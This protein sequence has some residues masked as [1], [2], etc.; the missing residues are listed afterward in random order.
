M[1]RI[2]FRLIV[3]AGVILALI[4]FPMYVYV[5]SA[6]TGGVEDIG[7]G[8]KFVDLYALSNFPFDQTN[9]T[10]EDVPKKW[11]ELDGQNVVLKGEMWQAFD[12]GNGKVGGFDLVYS[13][14]KCCVGTQPQIQHFVKA[15]VASGREAYYYPNQVMVTGKLHVDV[16]KDPEAGKVGQVYRLDVE[17]V[18][19]ST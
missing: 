19:P 6:V 12:S 15:R 7:G 4:G 14:S 16:Q 10:I 11:R 18:E 5:K 13:I 2:N 8:Y 1:D 17:K 3:F 9:G